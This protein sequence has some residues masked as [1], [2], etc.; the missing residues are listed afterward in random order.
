MMIMADQMEQDYMDK[1]KAAENPYGS[2]LESSIERPT[3][4]PGQ[5][6]VPEWLHEYMDKQPHTDP[7]HQVMPGR[8]D[9]IN[10]N[11]YLTERQRLKMLKELKLQGKM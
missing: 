10:S 4:M 7:Y 1:T 6:N 11:K 2:S 9:L 3:S 5:A 8:V